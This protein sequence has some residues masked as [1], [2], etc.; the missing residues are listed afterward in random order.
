M[1]FIK[2][3]MYDKQELQLIG[4]QESFYCGWISRKSSGRI[5]PYVDIG[6]I[7]VQLM[8]LLV[9]EFQIHIILEN[10]NRMYMYIIFFAMVSTD[11]RA[12]GSG[13]DQPGQARSR[14][15]PSQ[16]S[17]SKLVSLYGASAMWRCERPSQHF[18]HNMTP[19]TLPLQSKFESYVLA[20]FWHCSKI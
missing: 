18:V 17:I 19:Y 6:N 13:L 7:F 10:H 3:V 2:I 5:G 20:A 8:D 11:R 14:H 1:L 12:P 4:V 15:S 9:D 16:D